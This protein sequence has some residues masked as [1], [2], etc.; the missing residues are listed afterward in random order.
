MEAKTELVTIRVPSE[1]KSGM[2]KIVDK[3]MYTTIS[4][5]IRDAIREKMSGVQ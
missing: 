1:M 2:S 4:E 3:G 5:L